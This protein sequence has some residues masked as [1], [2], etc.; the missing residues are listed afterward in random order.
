MRIFACCFASLCVLLLCT[1]AR[2]DDLPPTPKGIPPLYGVASAAEKEGKVNVEL[3][4][5][6][7]VARIRVM[8]HDEFIQMDYWQ[9]LKSGVLGKDI[10]AY[11]LDGKPAEPKEVL[12]ALTKPRAVVYFLGYDKSKPVVPDPLYLSLLKEGSV[13]LALEMPERTPPP[14]P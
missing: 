11:G 10:R 8:D 12:K 6:R 3:S 5:L 7:D 2:A 14:L 9:L 13:V 1:I 4:E